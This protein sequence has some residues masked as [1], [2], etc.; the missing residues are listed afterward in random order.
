MAV[1]I[2]SEIFISVGPMAAIPLWIMTGMSLVGID[3]LL[4]RYN[5]DDH[6]PFIAGLIVVF[7]FSSV[8]GG[9]SQLFTGGGLVLMTLYFGTIFVCRQI[10]PPYMVNRQGMLPRRSPR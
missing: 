4:M 7:A 6:R 8:K 1:G 2:M 3:R 5:S 10:A 9:L